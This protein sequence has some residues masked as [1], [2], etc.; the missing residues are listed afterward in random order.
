MTTFAPLL[1][2]QAPAISPRPKHLA[3]GDAV[4]VLGTLAVVIGHVA[5]M[6][7]Q[8]QAPDTLN[9]WVCNLVNSMVRWA[10]PVY[11][12]LSGALL[13]DPAR[14]EAPS[15]FYRKRLARLGVPL[16]FWSAFFM[17]FGIYYT[18]WVKSGREAMTN[19]VLGQP[20]AHLHFIFRIAVLYAFTPMFRVFTRHAPRSMQISAVL[21][22]FAVWSADSVINGFMGTT[23]SAF[24][25]FAPFVSFYLAGYLLRESYAKREHIKYHVMGLLTC[26]A[27]LSGITGWLCM[28]RG[29]AWYP[30]ISL[31]MYDFL[32]PVRVPMAIFAWILLITFF[33]HRKP[34]TSRSARLFAVLAPTTLGLY[35]I[36]PMFREILYY[37]YPIRDWLATHLHMG[38]LWSFT[39]IDP[40]RPSIF[41]GIALMVSLVYVLSLASV[42]L[43]MRIPFVRRVFE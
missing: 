17:L 1:P 13:L 18:G 27:L 11:I 42:M 15:V 38:F 31:V 30:S 35:L 2:L 6:P 25:R 22:L 29:F 14:N 36:H 37:P 10:V 4:R 39:G 40:T 32:S 33:H 34:E 12:M 9:W 19:L 7:M 41:A 5:D 43:G 24:A 26:M 21:I 28:T 20:Y 23:L 16:V 3:Y 8:S